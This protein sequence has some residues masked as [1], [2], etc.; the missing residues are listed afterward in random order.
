MSKRRLLALALKASP[1]HQLSEWPPVAVLLMALALAL[2]DQDGITSKQVQ[3][4][5]GWSR[6]WLSLPVEVRAF[7]STEI[8][9]D[10]KG[11]INSALWALFKATKP[12]H[13]V[14]AVVR[15]RWE[16]TQPTPAPPEL[17]H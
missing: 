8:A 7:Y 2:D 10:P 3:Q 5:R 17:F 15:K 1:L 6:T 14:R 12:N 4:I 11:W 9:D 16:D 13:V